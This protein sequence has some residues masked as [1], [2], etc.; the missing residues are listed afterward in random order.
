MAASGHIIIESH[1]RDLHFKVR[2]NAGLEPVFF[3][4]EQVPGQ[5]MLKN[6]NQ[7]AQAAR[8]PAAPGLPANMERLLAGPYATV[9]AD[10]V[11]SRMDIMMETG[12]EP[13]W[14]AWP[15]GF[16][17]DALDSIC[18]KVGFRGTVSLS[19][20]AFSAQDSTLQV[21]RYTLTAKS[22]LGHIAQVFP[23]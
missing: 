21:G 6:L 12:H 19:P 23:N 16:A 3:H 17:T 15:Y 20:V 14:L 7:L 18:Q 4:P 13:R 8:S 22:T 2:T 10:L 9:A 5:A 1:T 11:A